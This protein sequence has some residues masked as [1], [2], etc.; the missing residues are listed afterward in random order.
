MTTDMRSHPFSDIG[1]G[2]FSCDCPL[3]VIILSP[4]EKT[5]IVTTIK[6]PF[7]CPIALEI[8]GS[9]TFDLPCLEVKINKISNF[10][11]RKGEIVKRI[12]QVLRFLVAKPP[13][14]ESRQMRTQNQVMPSLL[15]IA[16]RESDD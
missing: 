9:I 1:E 5:P 3:Y 6:F 16:A 11:I 4:F 10:E 2:D 13:I 7:F 14:E 8:I 15:F 12:G